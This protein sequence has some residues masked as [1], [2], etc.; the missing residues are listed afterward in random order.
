VCWIT[1]YK[2]TTKSIKGDNQQGE[3]MYCSNYLFLSA[4]ILLIPVQM[5]FLGLTM[6]R[7]LKV[8]QIL[9]FE[10]YAWRVASECWHVPQ[11]TWR[12]KSARFNGH[13]L[14]PALQWLAGWP[15]AH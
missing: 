3:S 10:L 1:I 4:F 2:D 8:W 12:G 5:F 13:P 9:L 14:P 6:R 15:V 7:Y 11:L